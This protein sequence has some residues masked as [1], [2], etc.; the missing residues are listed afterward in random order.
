MERIS[1]AAG[2]LRFA[3]SA[4]LYVQD[5]KNLISNYLINLITISEDDYKQFT[6]NGYFIAVQTYFFCVI[7]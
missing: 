6:E 7:Y 4:Q 2:N 1:H 3:K 5:M